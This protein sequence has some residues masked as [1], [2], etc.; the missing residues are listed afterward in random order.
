MSLGT[1]R[2][3]TTSAAAFSKKISFRV[4]WACPQPY[5]LW[6]GD[7][8]KSSE[9]LGATFAKQGQAAEDG[10]DPGNFLDVIRQNRLP[11]CRHG[12]PQLA[13]AS[14]VDGLLQQVHPP[15]QR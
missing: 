11:G 14:V 7:K 8:R 4:A 6:K 1:Q 10:I 2:L 3:S 9:H 5:F 15:P 13:L 12:L